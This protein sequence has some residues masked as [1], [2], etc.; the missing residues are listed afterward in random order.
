MLQSLRLHGLRQLAQLN[1]ENLCAHSGLGHGLPEFQRPPV[2]HK[3]AIVTF[4]D[5]LQLN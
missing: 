3:K 1:S 5:R 4:G 2:E